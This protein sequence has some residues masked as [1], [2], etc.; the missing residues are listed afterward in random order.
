MVSF[1][2]TNTIIT[3]NYLFYV[4]YSEVRDVH[5]FK[6]YFKSVRIQSYSGPYF[7][8]FGLNMDKYFVSL[9]I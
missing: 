5:D 6:D 8:A 2:Q 4:N 1:C 3:I 9:R 7:P